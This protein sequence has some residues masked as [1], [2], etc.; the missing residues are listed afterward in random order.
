MSANQYIS[1]AL[2]SALDGVIPFVVGTCDPEG[3]PNITFMSRLFYVDE[4]H[5]AISYQFMNKTRRNL[6]AN[7]TCLAFVTSPDTMR[8]WKLKLQYVEEQKEGPIFEEMEMQLMALSTPD[9]ISFSLYSAIICKILSI[10]EVFEGGKQ[11]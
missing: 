6:L 1:S 7:S 5:V 9:N 2:R 10:E 4:Q 8:M 3:I 11:A